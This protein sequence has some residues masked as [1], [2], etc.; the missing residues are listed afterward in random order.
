MD[1][2]RAHAEA[3]GYPL[4][5]P[6]SLPQLDDGHALSAID[7]RGRMGIFEEELT[8]VE[9]AIFDLTD[10]QNDLSAWHRWYHKWLFPVGQAGCV[11]DRAFPPLVSKEQ[12]ISSPSPG[13]S[14]PGFAAV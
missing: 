13:Q 12:G 4:K 6:A 9:C 11:G 2:L 1:A 5:S 10:S 14:G 8:P 7:L 3:V